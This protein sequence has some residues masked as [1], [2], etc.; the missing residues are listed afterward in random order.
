MM[1][2]NLINMHHVLTIFLVPGL[3]LFLSNSGLAIQYAKAQ[4][5]KQL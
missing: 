5:N 3:C 2:N 1:I 4:N